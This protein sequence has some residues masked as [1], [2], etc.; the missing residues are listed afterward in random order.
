MGAL[1]SQLFVVP[2][3]GESFDEWLRRFVQVEARLVFERR[4][5]QLIARRAHDDVMR[6]EVVGRG[7]LAAAA[8][9]AAKL[10][11]Q[12]AQRVPV[13]VFALGGMGATAPMETGRGQA[14]G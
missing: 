10:G 8:R 7:G 5:R 1:P 11:P 6:A 14:E 3:E 13:S 4:K 9:V 12:V 2:F